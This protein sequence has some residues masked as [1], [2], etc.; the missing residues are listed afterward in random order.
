MH[1]ALSV[2]VCLCEDCTAGCVFV[3]VLFVDA[4]GVVQRENTKGEGKENGGH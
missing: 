2:S 4:M 3:G 1:M